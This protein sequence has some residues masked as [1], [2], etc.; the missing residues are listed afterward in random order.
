MKLGKANFSHF[1]TE[2]GQKQVNVKHVQIIRIVKVMDFIIGME[3]RKM[4]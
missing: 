1:E 2:N 3:K 4:F